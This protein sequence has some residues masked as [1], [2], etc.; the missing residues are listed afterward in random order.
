MT[1]ETTQSGWDIDVPDHGD[2]RLVT[3]ISLVLAN[4]SSKNRAKRR[5][6]KLRQDLVREYIEERR[7]PKSWFQSIRDKL[8]NS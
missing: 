2:R 3:D 6:Q 7:R 8:F 1:G 5:Q 4:L